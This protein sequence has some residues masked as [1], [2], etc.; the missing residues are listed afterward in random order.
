MAKKKA[1]KDWEQAIQHVLRAARVERGAT[2]R[3]L[4]KLLGKSANVINLIETGNRDCS[5]GEFLQIC[6]LIGAEP[7]DIISR[8]VRW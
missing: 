7:C 4:S 2:Q 1:T 8:I 5:L 6:E 3:Q